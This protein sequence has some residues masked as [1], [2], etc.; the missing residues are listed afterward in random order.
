MILDVWTV[1]N[2]ISIGTGP[3][4]GMYCFAVAISI[5]YQFVRCQ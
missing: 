5:L 4:T 1:F 3:G 2:F